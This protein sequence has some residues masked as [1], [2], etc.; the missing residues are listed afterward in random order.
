MLMVLWSFAFPEFIC[1]ESLQSSPKALALTDSSQLLRYTCVWLVLQIPGRWLDEFKGQPPQYSNNAKSN[2]LITMTKIEKSKL[3]FVNI[4]PIIVILKFFSEFSEHFLKLAILWCSYPC[5]SGRLSRVGGWRVNSSRGY[6][7]AF[8]Y[9]PTV[10]QPYRNTVRL[11]TP[12]NVRYKV[13]R[14]NWSQ[15]G[16]DLV[17]VQYLASQAKQLQV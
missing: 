16:E 3:W 1:V 7:G 14:D 8:G 6:G 13:S 11:E 4:D 9:A 10:R 2:L 17:G 5:K 15:G 12:E